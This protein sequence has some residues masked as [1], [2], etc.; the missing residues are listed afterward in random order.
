MDRTPCV[1]K[2]RRRLGTAHDD[3]MTAES[4]PPG[5]PA[6]PSPLHAT[7]APFGSRG[8]PREARLTGPGPFAVL[9]GTCGHHEPY[10]TA[11]VVHS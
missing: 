8:V 6:V 2:V 9:F 5:L 3:A 7:R 10:A 1:V 11:M 4:A